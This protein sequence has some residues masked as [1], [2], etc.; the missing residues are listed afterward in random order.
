MTFAPDVLADQIRA[1]DPKHSAWVSAHAGSGKTYVLAHR[2]IRLLLRGADPQKILCLTFT[3]AAAANMSDRI[4]SVLSKWIELDDQQLKERLKEIGEPDFTRLDFARQLFAR[5]IETPG[6]L[7]IQTIHAFCERILH[8][9]PFEANVAA[10]FEAASDEQKSALLARARDVLFEDAAQT[11]DGALAQA[12]QTIAQDAGADSFSKALTLAL[13]EREALAAARILQTNGVMRALAHRTGLPESEIEADHTS[14]LLEGGIPSSEW[15]AIAGQFERPDKISQTTA[16]RV[17]VYAEMGGADTGQRRQAYI[18]IFT[19]TDGSP[20]ER[21]FI[22]NP[23][24]ARSPALAERLKAERDRVAALLVREKAVRFLR[25]SAALTAT[26]RHVQDNYSRLKASRGLLDFDDMVERTANL[27][28]QTGAA[29]VLYKLDAGIDHVLVDEAQDTSPVQWKILAAIAE[30]FFSGHSARKRDRTFFA[31]GDEKQS[32]FSFQGAEPDSFGTQRQAFSEKITGASLPFAD[33]NLLRSFRSSPAILSFVDGVF[34][35]AE[36]HKG[37]TTSGEAPRPH[38][39]HKAHLAGCVEVW[40]AVLPP[41][42]IETDDWRIPL[43]SPPAGAPAVALA[44]RIARHI[45]FLTSAASGEAVEDNGALRTVCPGDILI[46]VRKRDLLFNALIRALKQNG[47][48]VAGADRLKLLDHIAIEDLVAAGRVALLPQDDYTLACV[49]KSPLGGFD[50]DDL[51]A[52]APQRP[53][54]LI[55]ALRQSTDERHRT[56]TQSLESWNLRARAHGPFEF[57]AQLLGTDGA[58]RAFLARFG[59]EADEALGEFLRLALEFETR[60]NASLTAFLT[61]ITAAEAEVKRDMDA[62]GGAVRVMTVHASK[63]LEAKIVYLPDHC[64]AKLHQHDEAVLCDD[65]DEQLP[66]LMWRASEKD[67]P[68]F[69]VALREHAREQQDNE[70]RRLLYVALTRAEERLYVCGYKNKDEES[71]PRCWHEMTRRAMADGFSAAASAQMVPA[72]WNADE[73]VWRYGAPARIAA[74]APARADAQVFNEPD[75]LR[76]PAPAEASPAP[77]LRPSQSLPAADQLDPASPGS[78]NALGLLEGELAH[79][80]LQYLPGL[81]EPELRAA[82]ERF[83][84]SRGGALAQERRAILLDDVLGVIALPALQALFGPGSRAEVSLS[85]SVPDGEGGVWPVAGRIDRLAQTPDTIWIAD[86][87]TGAPKTA[88]SS[89]KRAYLRQLALYRLAVMEIFPGKRVRALIVW[90]RGGIEEPDQ[91]TLT[92]ALPQARAHA[93]FTQS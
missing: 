24:A 47:V 16:S 7:K 35:F 25:R 93:G 77:P 39:A 58:R 62:A 21:G 71:D 12:L 28:Q 19:K 90:T 26:A 3:R 75:W 30:E 55:D 8:L 53:G 33:V 64:R 72:Q 13:R 67:D 89:L 86:F 88:A 63:G 76:R 43:D 11:P 41:P 23:Q 31:V 65:A 45:A 4:F 74:P 56:F 6:G 27:F 61:W 42:D 44:E 80:L 15:P 40:P 50:D 79:S 87:K 78:G 9:F 85:A 36:H 52:L 91:A 66:V 57:Y 81:H 18:R 34:T 32:I 46:L 48:P 5:A 29:W 20:R 59:E 17:W 60:E 69:S 70:S 14:L 84:A 38:V 83:L 54:F 92:A 51:M 82:G 73:E 22:T 49:M 37:L 10:R 68:P 1:A 2:V